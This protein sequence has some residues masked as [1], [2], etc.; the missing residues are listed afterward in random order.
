MA[1]YIENPKDNTR[2]LVRLKND[3]SNVA[4]YKIYI[5]SL[6]HFT[7]LT[8]KYEEKNEIKYCF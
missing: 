3:Y 5:G 7:M 1:L 4:E 8:M 2:K 6:L